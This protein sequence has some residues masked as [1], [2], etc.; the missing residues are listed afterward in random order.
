MAARGAAHCHGRMAGV[1]ADRH[2]GTDR[3]HADRARGSVCGCRTPV[4]SHRSTRQRQV[5]RN[6]G[7]GLDRGDVHRSGRR[8]PG[9]HGMARCAV[10]LDSSGS[11]SGRFAAGRWQGPRTRE[12]GAWRPAGPPMVRRVSLRIRGE[13]LGRSPHSSRNRARRFLFAT[14][15]QRLERPSS[16]PRGDRCG[17][18]GAV[19]G[20][21]ASRSALVSK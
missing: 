11:R 10:S 1:A 4:H 14:P 18:P 13:P 19:P 20:W 5:A 2:V 17:C 3:R 8:A 21:R 9:C 6:D 7:G 16:H 15:P 12:H